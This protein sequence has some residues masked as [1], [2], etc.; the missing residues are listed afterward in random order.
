ERDATAVW[1][2]DTALGVFRKPRQLTCTS[3]VGVHLPDARKPR[4]ARP[5]QD[6]AALSGRGRS[7][8][9]GGARREHD[10]RESHGQADAV[11]DAGVAFDQ[12][13]FAAVPI[14]THSVA[15][16]RRNNRFLG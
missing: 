4:A 2:E 15:T 11:E 3:A 8:K 14:T 9:G 12:E 1:R 7:R 13:R 6:A 10:H 16:R 5:E